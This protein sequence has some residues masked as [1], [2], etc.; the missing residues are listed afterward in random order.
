MITKIEDYGYDGEGVGKVDGKVCFI[1]FTIKG[2]TVEFDI[3]KENSTFIKG[4][5]AKVVNPST[6][7]N[8]PQCEYFGRCGG[9]AYQHLSYEDEL[10]IKK[11]L[12]LRQLKKINFNGQVEVIASPH[13]YKYRNK[14]RLF[15]CDEGVGFKERESGNICPISHCEIACDLINDA[16]VYLNEYIKNNKLQNIIDS[17]VIKSVGENALINFLVN[18]ENV[19]NYQ[20]LYLV[21][22]ENFG[23]FET[24]KGKTCHK[25]GLRALKRNAFDLIADYSVN[26]FHQVNRYIEK[27]LYQKVIDSVIEKRVV[28]CYSGA[29]LLSILLAKTGKNVTAIELGVSEHDEAEKLK[30]KNDIINLNNICGD[31]QAILPQLDCRD[32]SVIVDPPR[33]GMSKGVSTC[34]NECKARQIIYISCNSASLVRDINLLTNYSL[35]RVCFFDMFASTGEYECLCILSH[36]L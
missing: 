20:G 12:L 33:S 16:I 6:L 31:C 14:I 35:E 34:L 4:K 8:T 25:V 27:L 29:G 15:V 28:N 36:K 2:E 11:T 21:L 23:I 32:K 13:R 24:C 30:K 7:R 26:S 17:I 3:V 22:G 1:P 9:C 10:D 5:L 19:C 18:K